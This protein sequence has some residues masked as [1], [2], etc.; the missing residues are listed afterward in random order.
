MATSPQTKGWMAVLF[1]CLIRLIS[2]RGASQRGRMDGQQ[3]PSPPQTWAKHQD[4]M[5]L[6]TIKLNV[7]GFRFLSLIWLSYCYVFNPALRFLACL[8]AFQH[9]ERLLLISFYRSIHRNKKETRTKSWQ[10]SRLT[11]DLQTCKYVS[12]AEINI[13][14]VWSHINAPR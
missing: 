14:K 13:S 3:R 6:T 5:A 10:L 7:S 2:V 8:I 11:R 1:L 12:W 4:S 9:F